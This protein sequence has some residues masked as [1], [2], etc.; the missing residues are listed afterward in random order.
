MFLQ[1]MLNEITPA[2]AFYRF[3]RSPPL[4]KCLS[5][6]FETLNEMNGSIK[7]EITGAFGKLTQKVSLFTKS[8]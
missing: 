6:L 4:A 8:K 7:S 1:K 2:I 5:L 3:W